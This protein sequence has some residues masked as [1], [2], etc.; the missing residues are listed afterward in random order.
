MVFYEL[1]SP[2]RLSHRH[3]FQGFGAM[4]QGA[5]PKAAAIRAPE[6]AHY[7]KA[8]VDPF[9]FD[10]RSIDRR[11]YQTVQGYGLDPEGTWSDIKEPAIR[12]LITGAVAFGTAR[13]VGIESAKAKKLGFVM[14]VVDAVVTMVSKKLITDAT[15]PVPPVTPK[16]KVPAPKPPVQGCVGC[17]R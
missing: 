2:G 7:E 8:G 17:Y 10:Y 4:V 13:A 9:D 11:L 12:G 16:E 14:G 5:A 15:A 3:P 1:S 6:G